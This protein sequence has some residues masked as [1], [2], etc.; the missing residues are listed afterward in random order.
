MTAK[1]CSHAR[2]LV[3]VA[4][5][6]AVVLAA[7]GSDN[8]GST[9]SPTA[10]PTTAAAPTTQGSTASTATTA[11]NRAQRTETIELGITSNEGGTFSIP[12]FRAGAEVAIKRINDHGGINGAKINV[13]LCLDDATPEGAVNCANKMVEEKVDVVYSAFDVASDAFM[14]IL[15]QA[16]IPYLTTQAWGDAQKKDPNAHILHSAGEAFFLAGNK[17]FADKGVKTSVNF[18]EDTPGGRVVL[19]VMND[20]AAKVGI[21]AQGQLVDPANPDWGNVVATAMTKNPELLFSTLSEQGCIGM[22]GAAR[23]F[24]FKGYILAGSCTQ[25]LTS[26]GEQ[27]IGTYTEGDVWTPD[28]KSFAPDTVK[29]Q[30]DQFVADMTAAGQEKYIPSYGI[31]S[32]AGMTEFGDILRGIPDGTDINAK[33]IA[34]ALDNAKVPGF[35]GGDLDC[36]KHAFPT[37]PRACRGTMMVFE[38]IAGPDGKPQR[39]P[40]FQ[41]MVDVS[42][43]A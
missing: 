6:G 11:T 7:C 1:R 40:L 32:Y 41:D 38:I 12:D 16:G 14:P 25:Y 24:G 35:L 36:T 3:G 17:V 26:L 23:Q 39:K 5:T 13:H 21:T 33:S 42:N 19:P 28:V 29:A 37:E 31:T 20:S 2:V 4:L 30:L 43:L 18:I 15:S 22:V 8:S 9:A 34:T 27:A 10:A